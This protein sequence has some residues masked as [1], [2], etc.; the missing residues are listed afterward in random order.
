MKTLLPAVFAGL[1]LAGCVLAPDPAPASWTDARLAET[2]PGAAPAFVERAVVSGEERLDIA[3]AANAAETARLRVR[4][5]GE[6]LRAPTRDTA[7][8]VVQARARALPPP[9]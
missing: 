6:A 2:P 3:E 4:T 8:F 1:V 9:Q 5:F 7:E